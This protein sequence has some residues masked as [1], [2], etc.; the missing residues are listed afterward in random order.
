[1]ELPT[2]IVMNMVN[3][4]KRLRW[5]TI[6]KYGAQQNVVRCKLALR[7]RA[8]FGGGWFHQGKVLLPGEN[9]GISWA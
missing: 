1:M 6:R 4:Y 8:R 5:H 2:L 7:L 9:V 3:V